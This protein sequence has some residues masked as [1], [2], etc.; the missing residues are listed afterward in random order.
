MK[1]ILDDSEIQELTI[2]EVVRTNDRGVVHTPSNNAGPNKSDLVKEIT[3]L[4]TIEFG[5]KIAGEINGVAHNSASK[6]GNGKD[7]GNEELRTQILSTKYDIAD[8]AVTKLMETLELFEPSAMD[9]PNHIIRAAAQ[10]S[11]IVEKVSGKEEKSQSVHL[12][13]YAPTQRK[14]KD[15]EVIDV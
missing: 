10:L 2:E 14:V 15:Y 1:L 4:D 9:N 6:Y 11:T 5:C 7:I 13:L 8:K 12:H 3:A